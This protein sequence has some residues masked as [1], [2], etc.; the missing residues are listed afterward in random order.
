MSEKINSKSVE[1][2]VIGSAIYE[3]LVNWIIDLD[4]GE[5]FGIDDD[6]KEW[7]AFYTDGKLINKRLL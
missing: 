4:T 5:A 2:Y 3:A 1:Q 6:Q 7:F